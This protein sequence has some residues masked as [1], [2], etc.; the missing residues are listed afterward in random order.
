MLDLQRDR[1]TSPAT[2]YLFPSPTLPTLHTAAFW[3]SALCAASVLITALPAIAQS[4]NEP[5]GTSTT[6]T[7]TSDIHDAIVRAVT[8]TNASFNNRSGSSASENPTY[9]LLPLTAR[10][11]EAPSRAVGLE[12]VSDIL[13]A[14]IKSDRLTQAPGLSLDS[15]PLIGDL[16][17][18]TGNLDMGIN[19]PFDMSIDNVMGETGLVLSTEL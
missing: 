18:E 9:D 1:L 15:I 7:S 14:Q 3:A 5:A 4:N 13:N 2:T 8:S 12:Q 16:V 17:D 6:N 11:L 10:K 19:L